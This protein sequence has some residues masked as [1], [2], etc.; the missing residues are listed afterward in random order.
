MSQHT[1]VDDPAW[2]ASIERLDVCNSMTVWLTD[3]EAHRDVAIEA[4]ADPLVRR[5]VS[6]H[7]TLV[8]RAN[9]EFQEGGRTEVST[10]RALMFR[11]GDRSATFVLPAGMRYSSVGY[12]LDAE[13]MNHLF[14]GTVPDALR[15]LLDP[16]G[17]TTRFVEVPADRRMRGLARSLGD[18]GLHGPLRILMLEGVVLQLLAAQAAAAGYQAPAERQGGLSGH[19]RDAVYAARDL[20]VADMRRP[21]GLAQLAAA[22]GLSE[23]RLNAGFRRAFDRSVFEVLRDERLEHARIVLLA[24]DVSLKEVAFRVGYN[25]PNNF[26]RAFS[27][28]FGAPPR[29]Y[30]NSRNRQIP[31][32]H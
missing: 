10:D 5:R 7:V 26:I 32:D 23:K 14:D 13:R 11:M 21:P 2:R 8:G 30:L 1:V 17:T 31:L 6:S 25:H 3:T 9:M 16:P 12:E 18:T 22:V 20:L 27:K 19:D 29:Q 4:H 28:R 15:G 24:E